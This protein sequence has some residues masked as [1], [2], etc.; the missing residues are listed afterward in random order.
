MMDLVK[1]LEGKLE[2]EISSVA[3][4]QFIEKIAESHRS[5][6]P[7]HLYSEISPPLKDV[8]ILT[9]PMRIRQ[10]LA[11][12]LTN[13]AKY[14]SRGCIHLY[15][16]KV[17][18]NGL[19]E[20]VR[21]I[22]IQV[23]MI[24][25]KR[26]FIRFQNSP[27]DMTEH[28]S[29]WI[30]CRVVDTGEGLGNLTA[31][32]LFEPFT[33]GVVKPVCWRRQKSG[34]NTIPEGDTATEEE[35]PVIASEDGPPTGDMTRRGDTLRSS[36]CRASSHASSHGSTQPPQEEAELS[37]TIKGTG[38]GLPL[39]KSLATKVL[40]GSIDL[41]EEW[42]PVAGHETDT[43]R[44]TVFECILP[45]DVD[46]SDSTP[47]EPSHNHS[48][49]VFKD[50][51]AFQTLRH[52]ISRKG[53][54]TVAVV[55]DAMSNRKIAKKYLKSLE[56]DVVCLDDGDK[57]VPHLEGSGQIAGETTNTDSHQDAEKAEEIDILF[58]DISMKRMGGDETCFLL[59]NTYGWTLPIVA[60]TGN[61]STK[62]TER[63]ERLGFTGV[64]GK[65]FDKEA[66]KGFMEQLVYSAMT[67]YPSQN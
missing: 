19:E 23:K 55:D 8:R 43:Q 27:H 57:V 17:V 58:L 42:I 9:D 46:T 38:L 12:G 49:K 4:A 15:C 26:N 63:Y 25:D 21:N 44:V 33:Q 16:G 31:L 60:M 59:R 45:M 65:P 40:G 53:R 13:A 37:R 28:S 5:F 64:L 24:W 51:L 67:D 54:P 14:C 35:K 32:Q 66:V 6:A 7:V 2:L 52:T 56:Y 61:V 62:E 34:T 41:R 1:L 48:F 39:A 22:P 18:A 47:T 10:I 11:N 3:L 50:M 36:L 29:E 20:A 30:L